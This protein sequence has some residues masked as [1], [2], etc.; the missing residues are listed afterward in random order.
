MTASNFSKDP[1][2]DNQLPG[3]NK[4]ANSPDYRTASLY[5]ITFDDTDDS[6]DAKDMYTK[7]MHQPIPI[8]VGA[9]LKPS[10]GSNASVQALTLCITPSSVNDTSTSVAPN[11]PLDRTMLA[12]ALLATMVTAFAL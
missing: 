8:F 7:H 10:N 11:L 1:C 5:G 2:E 9:V 12:T 3:K 6:L 4:T